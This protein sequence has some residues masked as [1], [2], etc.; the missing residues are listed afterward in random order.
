MGEEGGRKGSESGES[1]FFLSTAES[2]RC[3]TIIGDMLNFKSFLM[4]KMNRVI[5]TYH[6]TIITVF[7]SFFYHGLVINCISLLPR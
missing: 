6:C 2:N 5:I 7:H 1:D 3:S 4:N